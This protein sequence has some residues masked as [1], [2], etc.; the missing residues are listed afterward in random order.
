MLGCL[1]F[2]YSFFFFFFSSLAKE[3][4]RPHSSKRVPPVHDA[5]GR[6][7]QHWLSAAHLRAGGSPGTA[8]HLPSVLDTTRSTS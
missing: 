3:D 4:L 2:V 1:P 6:A 5:C 8:F 7:E